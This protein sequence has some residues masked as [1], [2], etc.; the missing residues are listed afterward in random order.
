MPTRTLASP[1]QVAPENIGPSLA[2]VWTEVDSTE[3]GSV[4]RACGMT[5]IALASSPRDAVELGAAVAASTSVTP[6][7]TII[8]ETTPGVANG[9]T[10]EI[11]AFC[12]IGGPKQVCQ[13]QVI[14]RVAPERMLD[15][16]SIVSSLA[17]PDLPLVMV[18]PR[19][20]DLSMPSGQRMMPAVDVLITDSARAASPAGALAALLR[21]VDRGLAV[22]D[23]AFERLIAWR[24][25]VAEA[26]DRVATPRSG[27]THAS[28]TAAA[29]DSTADLLLAWIESSVNG[30]DAVRGHERTGS[31]TTRELVL[32]MQ[33]GGASRKL[34]FHQYNRHVTECDE[35]EKVETCSLPRPAPEDAQLLTRLLADPR[36]CAVYEAALRAAVSRAGRRR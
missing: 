30:I 32:T 11:A 19:P 7:R 2:E 20:E 23:L 6:A 1:R 31:A 18:A 16:S 14:L 17:I 33:D 12:T 5:V 25:V 9:L 22:R 35:S 29:A 8:I 27:L 15:V 28:V 21:F 34:E 3:R 36:S 10:A 13:E 24:Q 26:W 4:V